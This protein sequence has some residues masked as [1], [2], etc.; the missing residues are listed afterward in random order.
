MTDN[1]TIECNSRDGVTIGMIDA[2]ITMA[3][4]LDQ[5]LKHETKRL[6]RSKV[7]WAWHSQ[8]VQDALHDLASNKVVRGL[9]FP[10][11]DEAMKI[12]NDAAKAVTTQGHTP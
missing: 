4:V 2:I 10:R 5:R 7:E 11:D 12:I 6:K 3:I 1:E 8:P 9:L